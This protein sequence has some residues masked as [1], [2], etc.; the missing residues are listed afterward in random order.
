MINRSIEVHDDR[1]STS[2]LCFHHGLYTAHTF[3]EVIVG[4]L[5]EYVH[6][7]VVIDHLHYC[8]LI[9]LLVFFVNELNIVAF[10]VLFKVSHIV[11]IKVFNLG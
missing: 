10:F 6:Q 1:C 8:V 5:L 9:W 3:P 7:A 11:S 4:S 2:D